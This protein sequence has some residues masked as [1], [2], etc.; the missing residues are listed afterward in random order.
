MILQEVLNNYILSQSG[1]EATY[2][3]VLQSFDNDGWSMGNG[4]TDINGSRGLL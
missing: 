3:T 2:S 4:D 1:A